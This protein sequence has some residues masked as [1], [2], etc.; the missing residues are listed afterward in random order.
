[1]SGAPDRTL[2]DAVAGDFAA[3]AGIYARYVRCT[4]ASFETGPPDAATLRERWRA[5]LADGLPWLVAESG[6]EVA[7]FAYAALYRRRLAYR[8]T[9]EHSIYVRGTDTRL[10]LGG[11]LIEELIARCAALGYRQMVAVIGD[12]DNAASIGFHA[13][14]GF[15]HAGTLGSVG[16]KF[17]RWVDSVL[18]IRPLG[19]GD[20][21]RP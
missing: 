5:V 8:F 15:R 1:M 14:H 13:R 16:Y 3:I 6:G 9:V 21:S 4:T 7:G 19:D 10:G 20:A 17:D 2:R 18:M 12:S 11:M